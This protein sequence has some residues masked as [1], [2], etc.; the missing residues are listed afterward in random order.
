MQVDI[1]T[2]T[3]MVIISFV[4]CITS[5]MLVV[6]KLSKKRAK[7]QA[8]DELNELYVTTI[9][10]QKKRIS[11][12]Q[13]KVNRM[14]GLMENDEEETDISNDPA[15]LSVISQRFNIPEPFLHTKEAKKYIKQFAPLI[16]QFGLL[17]QANQSNTD[18]RISYV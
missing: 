15:L 2:I 4:T 16:K 10:E 9:A 11:Q 12:L 18:S 1:I 7:T 6:P 17:D 3:S 8:Q 5:M 14:S 13:G